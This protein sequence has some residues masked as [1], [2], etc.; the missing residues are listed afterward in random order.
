[1]QNG[2]IKAPSYIIVSWS[3]VVGLILSSLGEV[4][5]CTFWQR[6][7]FE[8]I[9]ARIVRW[10]RVNFHLADFISDKVLECSCLFTTLAFDKVLDVGEAHSRV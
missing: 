10:Q 7:I 8:S 5:I 2:G 6:T 3:I 4:I 1:M 9:C